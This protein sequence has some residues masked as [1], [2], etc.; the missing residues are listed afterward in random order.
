MQ[1]AH[2]SSFNG[3][4]M[5]SVAKTLVAAECKLGLDS[6]LINVQEVPSAEWDRYGDFDVHVTH[7]HFP[8]EMKR[9]LA[10]PL[11]M[12]FVAHGVPEYVFFSSLEEG[13]KGYGHGDGWM[14]YQYWMQH[15][16]ASVT[17]WPR[18]QAIMQSLCDKSNR[19]RLV[20]LG[21]DHK[22]WTSGRSRGKFTG[23]PS[24]MAAENPHAIKA[25]YDLFI[26]WPWVIEKVPDA[27]LHNSYMAQDQQRWYFPLVNRNGSSYGAHISSM[28]WPHEELRHVLNSI[29]FY[30]NLVRYGDHNRIGMEAA[31]SGAKVISY[32]GNPYS[33]YWIDEGDQRVMAEQLV[34]VLRGEAEP[35]VPELVPSDVEMAEAMKTIYEQVLDQATVFAVS[36]NG[37]KETR[38]PVYERSV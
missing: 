25:P 14:L 5:H 6:H 20:P 32:K 12:V 4:G 22:F 21:L 26:A 19:V 1:I 9:R 3:S 7:T 29:D 28:L 30:C 10:R 8:N 38:E 33:H 16:D 18:H 27:C 31:L 24:V 17:F 23:N 2:W 35:R 37:H 15:A 11:K 13:K 34:S 36:S